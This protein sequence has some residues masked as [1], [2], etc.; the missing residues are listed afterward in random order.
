MPDRFCEEVSFK[1][2][3]SKLL[4]FLMFAGFINPLSG[5][6]ESSFAVPVDRAAEITSIS[7]P[8]SQ[9][10]VI[11]YVPPISAAGVTNVF[12]S[13]DSGTTYY[14]PDSD[15]C[16]ADPVNG[17]WV[18]NSDTCTMTI[19]LESYSQFYN[20]GFSL[21][22]GVPHSIVLGTFTSSNSSTGWLNSPPG[23]TPTTISNLRMV[24]GDTATGIAQFPVISSIFYEENR[25]TVYFDN[26]VNVNKW[27]GIAVSV[28][29]GTTW[30]TPENPGSVN[31]YCNRAPNALSLIHI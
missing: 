9:T 26:S 22:P 12:Y 4:V 30:V 8:N 2:K 23:S 3:L 13:T 14:P 6:I 18:V 10:L 20:Q 17:P 15:S 7:S 27:W 24:T 1:S 11:T 28:D 16:V 21:K 5:N 31:F 29:S 19:T 25:E